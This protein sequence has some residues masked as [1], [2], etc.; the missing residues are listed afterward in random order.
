MLCILGIETSCDDTCIAIYSKKKG[1]LFEKIYKQSFLHNKYGGVV[2]NIA[3]NEHKLGLCL[4][5]KQLDLKKFS[6]KGVAFTN[7][8]GLQGSLFLGV[9]FAKAVAYFLNV[10]TISINHLEGHILS[11][12]LSFKFFAFPYVALLISGGHT[13]LVYVRFVD[14]YFILGTTFDDSV[15]EVF[16][17]FSKVLGLGYPG[18]PVLENILQKG[19]LS[20]CKKI[21]RPLL[22]TSTFNYSFSG[23]KTSAKVNF[24]KNSTEDKSVMSSS[25]HNAIFDSLIVKVA[26]ALRYTSVKNLVIVGGSASNKYLCNKFAYFLKEENVSVF[27]PPVKY[28]TDNGAMIALVGSFRTV[29]KKKSN[30]NFFLNTKSQ[31]ILETI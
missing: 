31:L 13:F 29:M 1:V 19:T 8:P 17:K 28:C 27:T 9:S 4:L 22:H 16:D 2:P 11:I 21:A 24:L 3:L 26:L 10:R 7:G 18:G 20:L 23:L 15:G 30:L 6:I 14:F 12:L 5:Y 25:F